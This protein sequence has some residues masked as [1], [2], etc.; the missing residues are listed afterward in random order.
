MASVA[1]VESRLEAI[2]RRQERLTRSHG[3]TLHPSSS[4]PANSEP[5]AT[6]SRYAEESG[7]KR[8]LERLQEVR[9]RYRLK[10]LPCFERSVMCLQG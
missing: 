8:A 9:D 10:L 6:T 7:V 2:Q 4:D 5:D 1:A 3:V